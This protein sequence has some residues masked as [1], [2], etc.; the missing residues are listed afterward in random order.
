MQASVTFWVV[1]LVR[2]QAEW[3]CPTSEQG[4]VQLSMCSTYTSPN[5]NGYKHLLG[6][7]HVVRAVLCCILHRATST[8]MVVLT[9]EGRP[10][11]HATGT[12]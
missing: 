6:A 3:V 4:S 8:P 10:W 7:C 11:D 2:N 12:W 1:A 5:V 9:C